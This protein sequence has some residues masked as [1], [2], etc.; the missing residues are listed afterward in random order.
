MTVKG[1][2]P[3]KVRMPILIVDKYE[4][5]NI[6]EE[7][8]VTDLILFVNNS[9]TFWHC[10]AF[11]MK[12]PWL[13]SN[14]FNFMVADHK[15]PRFV[16]LK[17]LWH[18]QPSWR[19]VKYC[20]FRSLV[21]GCLDDGWWRISSTKDFCPVRC[22]TRECLICIC[23]L[24]LVVSLSHYCQGCK[25][26]VKFQWES[27]YIVVYVEHGHVDRTKVKTTNSLITSPL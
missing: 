11:W 16:P 25:M 15:T 12:P 7:G 27:P 13:F 9:S 19:Q 6:H 26:I 3:I 17:P 2:A 18:L 24:S 20:K 5:D 22:W 21:D 8:I 10:S 23:I 4:L 1:S 14:R